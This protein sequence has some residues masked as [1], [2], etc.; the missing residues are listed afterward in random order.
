MRDKKVR[1]SI[2]KFVKEDSKYTTQRP[3]NR[4]QIQGCQWYF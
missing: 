1:K 3:V 4:F 2:P